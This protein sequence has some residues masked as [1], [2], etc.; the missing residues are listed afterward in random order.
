MTWAKELKK[1]W[2]TGVLLVIFSL[3]SVYACARQAKS[4]TAMPA[5]SS[6]DEAVV[7]AQA[8]APMQVEEKELATGG[9]E[10]R[11]LVAPRPETGLPVFENPSRM[12]TPGP[13]FNKENTNPEVV[14]QDIPKEATG[15]EDWVKAFKEDKINP[16]ESLDLDK[17]HVPP[18]K[19]DVEIPAVGSMPNV[20]FPHEPHTYWL[21]CTNCH[22]G[23]FMMKKGG[24]PISMVKIVNG[25]FCGRCHGRVAFPIA[26]CTRCHVKP[27]EEASAKP[28]K[29]DDKK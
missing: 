24:N 12:P 27:K 11:S 25:E 3:I 4:E 18:L 7:V 22:P 1:K 14:M 2:F 9:G 23:I 26:N 8:K 15:L 28:I 13:P 16:H 29:A 17:K 20:I 19:F 10:K 21:D 5:A 6:Q